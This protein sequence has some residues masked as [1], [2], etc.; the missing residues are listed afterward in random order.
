MH[1]YLSEKLSKIMQKPQH[2]VAVSRSITEAIEGVLI[3]YIYALNI[4]NQ[5]LTF[6]QGGPQFYFSEPVC[7][8]NGLFEDDSN[9][10]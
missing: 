4:S 7:N 2:E 3:Y 1:F 6:Y 8:G 10:R 5:D 9:K